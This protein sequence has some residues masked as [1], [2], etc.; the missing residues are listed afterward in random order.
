MNYKNKNIIAIIAIYL[1]VLLVYVLIPLLVPFTKGPA[2]WIIYGATI[3]SLLLSFVILIISFKSKKTIKSLLYG[4]PIFRIGVIYFVL[5]VISS[6]AIFITDG[7]VG[8]PF[9]V[10][11]ICVI[12]FF[13]L[14][15]IGVAITDA[16]R[17]TVEKVEERQSN[18]TALYDEIVRLFSVFLGAVSDDTTREKAA[19]I[20]K[21]IKYSDPIS[22]KD[23][24]S[25][26]ERI[27]SKIKNLKSLAD[28]N[29]WESV[30]IELDDLKKLIS[31]RN[32]L[33]GKK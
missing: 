3:L 13:A 27:I 5:Q 17:R 24:E 20:N 32:V 4:V 10:S 22:N 23:S 12:V 11:L 1:S 16:Q 18:K 28:E 21:L 25:V 6:I 29:D 31:E 33:A 19:S 9:W 2:S 8:T 7:L 26:E 30:S 15:V 14:C